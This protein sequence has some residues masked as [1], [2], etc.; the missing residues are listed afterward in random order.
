MLRSLSFRH[1]SLTSI[2]LSLPLG[3]NDFVELMFE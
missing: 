2:E 1:T 3:N